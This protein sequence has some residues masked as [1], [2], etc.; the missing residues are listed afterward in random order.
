MGGLEDPWE[1]PDG[2]FE[3]LMASQGAGGKA[4]QKEKPVWFLFLQLPRHLY[5][6]RHWPQ[7]IPRS[8]HPD[9]H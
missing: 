5:I 1:P 9:K 6:T 3:L 4:K 2:A 7:Q 8:D